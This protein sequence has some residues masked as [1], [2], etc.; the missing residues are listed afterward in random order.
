MDLVERLYAQEDE[1]LRRIWNI[2]PFNLFAPAIPLLGFKSVRQAIDSGNRDFLINNIRNDFFP[3]KPAEYAVEAKRQA[4]NRGIDA[5]NTLCQTHL[6]DCFAVLSIP[7]IKEPFDPLQFIA[8]AR[9]RWIRARAGKHRLSVEDSRLMLEAYSAARAWGLGRLV[10]I[11]DESP[12]VFHSVNHRQLVE[13][14]FY[15]C[16]GFRNPQQVSNDIFSWDNKSEVKVYGAREQPF[17]Q[18]AKI[19][20]EQGNIRYGSILMKMFLK[21]GFFDRIYDTYGIEIVVENEEAVKRLVSYIRSEVRGTTTLEKY[22]RIEH[23]EQPTFFCDK[24]ILRIPVRVASPSTRH[25][26]AGDTRERPLEKY[27]RLP[28][29]IQVRALDRVDPKAHAL[30]KQQQYMRVFPLWYPKEIYE[31]LLAEVKS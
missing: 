13:S 18:R 20:D 24:F 11:I 12:E 16:F 26:K 2:M 15:N 29:E 8:E 3:D 6:P 19:Y 31:P 14:W 28:V 4:M 17:R 5:L 10:L 21:Q 1:S 22:E 25:H 9:E 23:P 27:I 7:P 30:Y